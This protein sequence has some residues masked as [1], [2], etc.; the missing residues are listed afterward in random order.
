M[1]DVQSTISFSLGWAERLRAS[2]MVI[3]ALFV[4]SGCSSKYARC[5]TRSEKSGEVS[6]NP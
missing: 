6:L 3:A 1:K 2:G 4:V 5:A